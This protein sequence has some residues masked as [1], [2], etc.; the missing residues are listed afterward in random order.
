MT[1]DRILKLKESEAKQKA[2]L[3]KTRAKLKKELAE[4]EEKK[5]KEREEFLI[6]L[7]NICEKTAKDDIQMKQR[8]ISKARAELS[9]AKF[10]KFE[11]QFN[12]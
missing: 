10:N 7:G 11:Q 9:E 12:D 1:P 2:L 5:S 6:Q 4:L 3:Q 8:L